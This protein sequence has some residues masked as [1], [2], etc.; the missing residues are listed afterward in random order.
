MKTYAHIKDNKVINTVVFEDKPVFQPEEGFFLDITTKDPKPGIN[1]SYNPATKEFKRLAVITPSE[2]RTPSN[3][4]FWEKFKESEQ[5][6]LVG[7][8][9]AK[10]KRFL[11]ELR[12]KEQINLDDQ[13]VVN[14]VNAMEKAGII[15]TGRAKEIL[16]IKA[17]EE[18]T[19]VLTPQKEIVKPPKLSRI[20]KLFNFLNKP[21]R[22]NKKK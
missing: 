9:N 5:E 20:K 13:K 1:W 18:K 8:N 19:T 21:L 14:T 7:S 6:T 16:G 2:T 4:A 12:L 15:A 22:I 17:E 3:I 10:I 11:Y